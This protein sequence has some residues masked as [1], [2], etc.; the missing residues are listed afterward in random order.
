MKKRLVAVDLFSGCGGL[1]LG[2]TKAG[3][4]VAAAVE[5]N[6]QA[7]KVYRRNHPQSSLLEQDIGNVT[8]ARLRSATGKKKITLLAGCAPCQGFCALTRK[9]RNQDARN[10]LLLDM[11]RL[12]RAVRPKAVLM[13]NV[14]GILTRGRH[15]F[16]IFLSG[17]RKDGYHC[18]YKVV[19]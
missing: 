6:P 7:A 13:E 15:V 14:P 9:P 18:T 11:L 1:S 16:K 12:V 10:L 4:H 2:L 8:A 19:Q 3:F 17:L 5:N